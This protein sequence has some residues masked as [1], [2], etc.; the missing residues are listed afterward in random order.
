PRAAATGAPSGPA[1]AGGPAGLPPPG[2]AA[3]SCGPAAG[4]TPLPRPPPRPP[5]TPRP[6]AAA[7]P[8]GPG[9]GPVSPAKP[10][11][12]AHARSFQLM[13][14]TYGPA[15]RMSVSHIGPWS[16]MC[17]VSQ[18]KPTNLGS[19]SL[20]TYKRSHTT[21]PTDVAPARV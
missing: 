16:D 18:W 20:N 15:V 6:P 21:D 1:A 7:A 13:P 8:A 3:G 11:F 2:A 17:P 4:G 10:R 9:Y 14:T 12:C 19:K 5:P